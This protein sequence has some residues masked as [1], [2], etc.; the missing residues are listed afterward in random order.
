ME[1]IKKFRKIEYEFRRKKGTF[2][3]IINT[4][5]AG[6]RLDGSIY[7]NGNLNREI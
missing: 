6:K 5:L 1:E 4:S 2:N 3:K 7:T